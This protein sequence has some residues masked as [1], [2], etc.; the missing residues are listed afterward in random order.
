MTLKLPTPMEMFENA[1]TPLTDAYRRLGDAGDWLRSDWPPGYVLS[2]DQA[3]AKQRAYAAIAAAKTAIDK[4]Q[5]ALNRA[6]EDGNHREQRR[7]R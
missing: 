4:A 1:R 6:I 7:G 5:N 2:D 3:D